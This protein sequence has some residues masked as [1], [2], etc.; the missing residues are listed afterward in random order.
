[1]ASELAKAAHCYD[2]KSFHLA[3]EFLDQERSNI[4][5]FFDLLSI[6]CGDKEVEKLVNDAIHTG[7][8]CKRFSAQRLYDMTSSL[9]KTGSYEVLSY[10]RGELARKLSK[11]DESLAVNK[12]FLQHYMKVAG[13]DDVRTLSVMHQIANTY[14]SL[15]RDGE[16]R[17]MREE[18]LERRIIVLGEFHTSTLNAMNNLA[19]SYLE[20]G[21]RDEQKKKK[22]MVL[23]EKVWMIREMRLGEEHPDSRASRLLWEA[24]INKS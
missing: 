13:R 12:A 20:E 3:F 17:V 23:L 24:N 4:E 18:V 14:S 16:S 22:A 15:G 1:M 7:L 19:L 2:C 6:F 21:G 10:W 9:K 5:T 8:L 11:L